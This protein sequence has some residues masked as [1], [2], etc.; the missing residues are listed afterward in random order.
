MGKASRAKKERANEPAKPLPKAKAGNKVVKIT[1]E[2]LE[3]KA[4]ELEATYKKVSQKMEKMITKKAGKESKIPKEEILKH[5]K[6]AGIEAVGIF[7]AVAIML[8]IELHSEGRIFPGTKASGVDVS[9]MQLQKAGEKL[10]GEINNY[11]AQPLIF[12]YQGDTFEV[13]PEEI[14]L[15]I[16]VEQTLARVPSF[17]FSK[18]SPPYLLATIFT[19]REIAG[20]VTLDGD[21]IIKVLEQKLNLTDKKAQNAGFYFEDEDL[22][23]RPEKE[24]ITINREKLIKAARK[25]VNNLS[26]ATINIETENITPRITAAHIEQQKDHLLNMLKQPITLTYG[27]DKLKIKLIDHLDA[28]NFIEKNSLSM[29]GKPKAMP[30]IMKENGISIAHASP[31]TI[32]SDI[33]VQIDP[34]KIN[35][36]LGDKLI[37][38][39]ETPVSPANIF[40]DEN[41]KVIVEGQGENGRTIARDRL[42][43]AL[44][45]AANNSISSVPVPVLIEHAPLTISDD[46]REKGIKELIATGHSAYYGSPPNRIFNINFGTEKYNGMLIAPGEEFSFN[47]NLGEVDAKSG[48]LPEKVIKSN[49]IELEFGGGI[50]QVSTTLYRAALLAGLPITDR[51]PHSWKVSYYSQSMGNGLDATIYPGVADLKFLNDTPGYLLIQSYTQGPEAYFKIYGTNDGRKVELNGP[52]G[53]GLTFRWNRIVTKGAEEI[54][55]EIWSRYK[56]IP[57]P[58]PPPKEVSENP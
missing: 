38:N 25:N 29:Q 40:T 50:C 58:E 14:G 46:L 36:F 5:L 39:I 32:N 6:K 37:N 4:A 44:T 9:Y 2:A 56:P 10:Q 42:A 20:D 11:M 3:K 22:K 52:F 41:G 34:Q 31:V 48:F 1:T 23:I 7:A 30:I 17:R 45:L 19:N 47:D 51:S 33:T 49:K 35:N 54:S 18:I 8:V 28:I 27:D 15:H 26:S 16:G 21:K 24:G 55:E 57:P 12:S 53:G 43:Q 13:T